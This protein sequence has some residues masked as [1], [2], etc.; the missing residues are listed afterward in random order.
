[1]TNSE[2]YFLRELIVDK[3]DFLKFNSV[4]NLQFLMK[5][6]PLLV[7]PKNYWYWGTNYS[8]LINFLPQKSTASVEEMK[9][10]IGDALK[11][12][13]KPLNK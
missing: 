1:M 2:W 3:I 8:C 13:Y 7:F 10:K 6:I 9:Q 5:K 4:T 11:N 12:G